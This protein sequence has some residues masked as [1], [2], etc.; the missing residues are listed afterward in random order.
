MK[1]SVCVIIP[2]YKDSKTLDRAIKSVYSQ[3]RKVDEIIVVNDCS[4]ETEEIKKII[5]LYPELVYHRND[6]N[7]GLAATRNVGIKKSKSDIITFLDADDE[8]HFKKIE[9]QLLFFQSNSA[10]SCY[11]TRKSS[12]FNHNFNKSFRIV[13]HN[14][15]KRL[16]LRNTIL[17]AGIMISR[18]LLLNVEGYDE[19]LRSC[20]D[21]DLWLRLISNGVNIVSLKLPLYLYYDNPNSLSNNYYNISFYETKLLEKHIINLKH[22]S[23]FIQFLWITTILKQINRFGKKLNDKFLSQK[24]KQENSKLKKLIL[25][26]VYNKVDFIIFRYVLKLIIKINLFNIFNCKNN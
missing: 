3:S 24:N 11:S 8:I 23:V 7:I 14:N 20:E 13:K 22:S 21:W 25:N 19:N 10:I 18:K 4:P 26:N 12:G 2:C 6:K 15:I 16:L 1:Y 9:L 5:S 17:G